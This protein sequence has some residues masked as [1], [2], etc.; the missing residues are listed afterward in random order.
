[1]VVARNCHDACDIQQILE[2]IIPSII[3]D[4]GARH[5]VEQGLLW[6]EQKCCFFSTTALISTQK[7][8]YSGSALVTLPP[9]TCAQ[10][11]QQVTL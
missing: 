2:I 7:L 11:R 8:L 5:E 4:T 6:L 1:M 9:G 10:P 3:T